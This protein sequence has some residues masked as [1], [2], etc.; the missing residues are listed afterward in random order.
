MSKMAFIDGKPFALNEKESILQFAERHNTGVIPTLCDD[1]RL[2]PYGA[3]RL[4]SV[5]V[6]L[7][8]DGP[9]KVVASCS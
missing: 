4:C 7:N 2:E 3:C 1:E 5:D 9:K 8:E 6:S